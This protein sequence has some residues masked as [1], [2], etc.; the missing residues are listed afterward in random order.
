MKNE[1]DD[2]LELSKELEKEIYDLMND[3][4]K[5]LEEGNSEV[6]LERIRSAWEKLPGS[7]YDSAI[8]YAILEELTKLLN[9]AGRY[10]EAFEVVQGFTLYLESNG[11][12]ANRAT[13]YIMHGINLL[14]ACR[15]DLA[16]KAFYKAVKYGAVK[17]DFMG[18]HA[19]YFDIAKKKLIDNKKIMELFFEKVAS[20]MLFIDSMEI[21]ELSEELSERI[22]T[23]NKQGHDL[24]MKEEFHECLK[25]RKEALALI[26]Q[27]QKLYL[28]AFWLE[29]FIGECYFT[30]EEFKQ[31][32]AHFL[33][34][35][36]NITTIEHEHPMLMLRLGELYFELDRFNEAEKFLLKAYVAE[37]KE[38]FETE[39]EKYFNFLKDN[40]K[41]N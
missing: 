5:L 28:E 21:D 38:I 4:G 2:E 39:E 16:K 18:F 31:S 40:V 34:A 11:E 1:K 25:V 17:M 41:L 6:S 24:Y 23:L 14:F 10:D 30:L 19:I 12:K 7:K 22:E 15:P 27:P 9:H 26:P 33:N 20:P 8:S 36:R 37:G 29:I 13:P 32:L 3:A 35:K